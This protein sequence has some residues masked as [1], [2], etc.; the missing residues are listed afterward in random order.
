MRNSFLTKIKVAVSHATKLGKNYRMLLVKLNYLYIR[1]LIRWIMLPFYQI[2]RLFK[3]FA[4]P[5]IFA[6]A[7]V[8]SL[9]K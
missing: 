5:F 1:F 4:L 8:I 6:Y 7:Y 3:F 9:M 2:F